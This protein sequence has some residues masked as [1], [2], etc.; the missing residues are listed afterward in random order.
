MG[1]TYSSIEFLTHCNRGF[2]VDYSKTLTLGRQYFNP[3]LDLE[4]DIFCKKHFRYK[5]EELERLKSNLANPEY[6]MFSEPFFMFLGAD[7]V[8]SVDY[9]DYEDATIIHDLCTE[10]P[11][12][13]KNKYTCV[14]DGGLLE[15]VFDFPVAFKNAMD[16]VAIGGHLIIETPGNNLFGHGFYQFSPELFYSSLLEE[17]GFSNTQ[18]FFK[19]EGSNKWYL[20]SNPRTI[21]SRTELS[22][23]WKNL[24]L[25]VVSEKAHAVPDKLSVYQS[26]Y[27]EEWKSK[28]IIEK[29]KISAIKSLIK[30]ILPGKLRVYIEHRIR[31]RGKFNKYFSPVSLRYD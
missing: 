11:V 1:I 13:L 28:K 24:V 27:E 23:K 5:Q 7:I 3:L 20:V 6:H 15:H 25:H 21:H 17:N 29:K 4:F 8:D 26:D 30:V 9:S 19:D 10:I 14:F 16:M 18:V 22:P 12:E 2:N 31:T